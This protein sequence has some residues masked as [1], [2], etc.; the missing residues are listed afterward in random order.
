M[1]KDYIEN[2]CECEYLKSE[3]INGKT[4]FACEKYKD[5]SG[6]GRYIPLWQFPNI[7]SWC[8]LEDYPPKD[9]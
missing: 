2:C 8:P 6:G 7:P 1:S 4:G 9:D 3:K 5:G